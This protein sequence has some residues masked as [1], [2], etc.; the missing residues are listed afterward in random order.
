MTA[1]SVARGLRRVD[2]MA[3]LKCPKCSR[4]FVRRS[5]RVGWIEKFLSL[6][7]VYPFKCQLCGLRFRFL[8]RGVRYTRVVEDRRLYDRLE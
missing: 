5:S 6:F 8:Q 1:S 7:Y 2:G 3:S 4:D